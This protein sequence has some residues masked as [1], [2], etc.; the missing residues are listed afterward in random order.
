MDDIDDDEHLYM[1]AQEACA[2]L[3]EYCAWN[4]IT[5]L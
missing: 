2:A 4:E 5:W 1:G 3:S